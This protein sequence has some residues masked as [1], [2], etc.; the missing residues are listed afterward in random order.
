MLL[1]AETPAPV[2]TTTDWAERRV[3]INSGGIEGKEMGWLIEHS[4]PSSPGRCNMF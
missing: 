2:R 1:S 3:S 4:L